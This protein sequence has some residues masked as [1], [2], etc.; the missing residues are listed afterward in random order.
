M[1]AA[2]PG[3]RA[4]RSTVC[5]LDGPAILVEPKVPGAGRNPNFFRINL[6]R[7]RRASMVMRFGREGVINAERGPPA[8]HCGDADA[9]S[10]RPGNA[11]SGTWA[12]LQ[13]G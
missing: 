7:P 9:A 6:T 12:I 13:H 11:G 3:N 1:A 8:Q 2:E 5:Q 10:L 4:I